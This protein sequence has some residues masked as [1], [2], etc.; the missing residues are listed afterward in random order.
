MQ[1]VLIVAL[2]FGAALA[3]FNGGDCDPDWYDD[4]YDHDVS[5]LIDED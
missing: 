2:I 5:G 1:Y 3:L 4:Y